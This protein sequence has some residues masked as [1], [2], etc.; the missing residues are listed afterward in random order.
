MYGH[1]RAHAGV[2]GGQFIADGNAHAAGLIAGV[3]DHVTQTAHCFANRTIPGAFR[4]GPGLAKPGNAYHDQAWVDRRKFFVPH[5]PTF[6]RARAKVFDQNIGVFDQGFDHL[7]AFGGTQI[8]R[9]RFLVARHHGP[10]QRFAV[11]LFAAPLAHGVADI[12][13]FAFDDLGAEIAQQLATKGPG[14][15]LSHFDHPEVGQ[16]ALPCVAHIVPSGGVGH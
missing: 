1:H 8:D 15:K 13:L 16:W 7:L 2:H 14:Q 10:P 11:G 6:H 5:A 12:G 3:A 9:D 4:I